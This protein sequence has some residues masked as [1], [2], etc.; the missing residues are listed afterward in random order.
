LYWHNGGSGDYTS[1][2]DFDKSEQTGVAILSNY[3]DAA[4]DDFSV[5]EIGITILM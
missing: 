4:K 1:F 5:D 2:I 3:G